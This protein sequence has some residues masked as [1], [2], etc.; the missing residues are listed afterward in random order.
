MDF[1]QIESRLQHYIGSLLNH[2][3]SQRDDDMARIGEMFAEIKRGQQILAQAFIH[4]VTRNPDMAALLDAVNAVGTDLAATS[5]VSAKLATDVSNA[6]SDLAAMGDVPAAITA[7]GAIK[8]TLEGINT[9]LG[10]VDAALTSALPK[11]A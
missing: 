6:A 2:H 5:T 4:I 10:M 1:E 7:L 11:T 9:N 8:T 3:Q